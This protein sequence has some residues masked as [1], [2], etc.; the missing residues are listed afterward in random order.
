MK[1]KFFV[2]NRQLAKKEYNPPKIEVYFI[3]LESGIVLSSST[4]T[5]IGSNSDET[6]EVNDWVNDDKGIFD[7][8]L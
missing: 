8:D 7:V 1:R 6:I 2:L 5:P 3:S 4:I